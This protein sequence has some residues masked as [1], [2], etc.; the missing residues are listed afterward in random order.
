MGIVADACGMMDRGVRHRLQL[1]SIAFPRRRSRSR[2]WL[3]H[4][5]RLRCLRARS[6][7]GML[8]RRRLAVFLEMGVLMRCFWLKG[9]VG[10]CRRTSSW[11]GVRLSRCSL[12]GAPFASSPGAVGFKGELYVVGSARVLDF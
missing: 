1:I 6:P 10:G 2:H 3:L 8:R 5:P 11:H 12:W 4:L 9:V 7:V